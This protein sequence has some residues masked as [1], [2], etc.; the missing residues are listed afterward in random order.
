M[1][2]DGISFIHQRGYVHCDIKTDNILLSAS[3]Q[4]KICDLGL[5]TRTGDMCLGLGTTI[6]MAPE[7]VTCAS[8][9]VCGCW[10]PP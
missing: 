9:R 2:I 7:L 5:A 4:V 3:G 8:H 1:Q 6:Y 10:W